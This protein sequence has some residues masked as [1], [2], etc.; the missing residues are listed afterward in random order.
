MFYLLWKCGLRSG[1]V[2]E[3][4]LEDLDLDGRNFSVRD[5]KGQKDRTV[6]VTDT[7]IQALRAYLAVRGAGSGEHVFLYRNAPL[8][9]C[10]IGCRIKAAGERVGIKVYPHRLRH[11]CATQLLNAGCR[12]TSIQRFLGHKE[13]GT[14]MIYARVHDKTVAEDYFKAMEQVEQKLAL[15]VNPVKS[16]SSTGELLFLVNS[17]Q[18]TTLNLAQREI[19]SALRSGLTLLAGQQIQMIDVNVLVDT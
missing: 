17:L 6:Y 4:R 1:E 13:L 5:G 18:G 19:V 3:L 12:I 8:S 16:P 2:E 7:T 10:F 9:R 11:T 14:T 15:P